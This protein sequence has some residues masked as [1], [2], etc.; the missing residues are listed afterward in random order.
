MIIKD[1]TP[2]VSG[3][4]HDDID[5]FLSRATRPIERSFFQEAVATFTNE[6]KRAP[7]EVTSFFAKNCGVRPFN[8]IFLEIKL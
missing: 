6:R 1:L 7:G 5:K 2:Y 3:R 4:G 8:I